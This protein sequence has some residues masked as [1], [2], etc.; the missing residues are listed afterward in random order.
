M[1][2][3]SEG[4]AEI[5][6]DV[7][8]CFVEPH[9]EEKIESGHAESSVL[10]NLDPGTGGKPGGGEIRVNQG[11]KDLRTDRDIWR[12]KR[13]TSEASIEREHRTMVRMLRMAI[14]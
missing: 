13:V 7:E 10:H 11:Q 2:K 3:S 8:G 12:M 4:D 5:V 14:W 9:Q 1:D 6:T